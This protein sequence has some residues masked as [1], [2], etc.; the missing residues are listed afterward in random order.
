[1]CWDGKLLWDVALGSVERNRRFVKILASKGYAEDAVPFLEIGDLLKRLHQLRDR[2]RESGPNDIYLGLIEACAICEALADPNDERNK[3]V[4]FEDV[5]A[6][7]RR[8][9]L[10]LVSGD[11]TKE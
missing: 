6:R 10:H 11:Q 8:Q 1:M 3:T 4:D 2:A 5:A 7:L 9:G